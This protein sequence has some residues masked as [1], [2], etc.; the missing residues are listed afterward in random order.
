[1]SERLTRS[2]R[3]ALEF[4][5]RARAEDHRTDDGV[6]SS[7]ATFYDREI[8]TAVVHWRTADALERRGLIEYG[9]WD[10]EWGTEIRLAE[11]DAA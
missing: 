5:R 6:V 7:E 11:R 8:A 3:E 10:P 9:D 4:L 2:Q 1:M